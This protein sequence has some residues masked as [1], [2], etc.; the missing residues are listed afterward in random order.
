V[1]YDSTSYV[2]QGAEKIL[3]YE[4]EI[5]HL[6]T[7]VLDLKKMVDDLKAE[8]DELK[9]ENVDL[10]EKY[11]RMYS[12][13][14][15]EGSSELMQ[16]K[17]EVQ[18]LQGVNIS[19]RKTKYT[20]EK[21]LHTL[22]K[23]LHDAECA[24]K[25]GREYAIEVND[26]LGIA[27]EENL[28]LSQE[29]KKLGE[30]L[31]LFQQTTAHRDEETAHLLNENEVLKAELKKF[32]ELAEN[33]QQA[34][35]DRAAEQAAA[36]QAAAEQVATEQAA[37]V[38]L[39]IG[40]AQGVDFDTLRISIAEAMRTLQAVVP[41]HLVMDMPEPRTAN[42][43]VAQTIATLRQLREGLVFQQ[44]SKIAL[45]RFEP[46][47]VA[48]FFR[49]SKNHGGERAFT[50]F[51]SRSRCK[52]KH[53]L[54]EESKAYINKVAHFKD[55]YVLGRIVAKEE[56]TAPVGGEA[57]LREGSRYFSVTVEALPFK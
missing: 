4:I 28:K 30:S 39:E 20:L 15:P 31:V 35:V 52:V 43:V 37:P 32:K 55:D 12:E 49:A 36:E 44:S 13:V 56:R 47:D 38:N 41:Q 57:G 23:D 33:G 26:Q 9:T 45:E 34:E 6:K 19:L 16:L 40:L 22:Q 42:D 25:D 29:V 53:I 21:D 14:V 10:K 27:K 50:V 11:S 48:I 54:S 5:K 2:G 7:E 18:D 1:L 24:N 8:N 3:E 51:C 17:Q 46:G